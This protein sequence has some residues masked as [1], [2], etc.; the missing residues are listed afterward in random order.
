MCGSARRYS[1]PSAAATRPPQTH[2]PHSAPTPHPQQHPPSDAPAPS[3]SPSRASAVH[4]RKQTDVHS[5]P[6]PARPPRCPLQ[7]AAPH[8]ARPVPAPCAESPARPVRRDRV[9]PA[10]P[11]RQRL[12]PHPH[13]R[14]PP[15]SP[16][17]QPACQFRSVHCGPP[18]SWLPSHTDF[19]VPQSSAPEQS[20]P[21]PRQAPPRPAHRPRDRTPAHPADEPRPESPEQ[22]SA[23]PPRCAPRLPPAPESPSS[24]WWKATD[25]DRQAHSNPLHPARELPA[26]RAV[27]WTLALPMHA[28]S[29]ARQS[30]GCAPPQFAAPPAWQ[31]P[32]APTPAASHAAPW[33]MQ[34]P[35]AVDPTFRHSAAARDPRPCARHPQ[36]RSPRAAALSPTLRHDQSVVAVLPAPG[37][38]QRRPDSADSTVASSLSPTSLAQLPWCLAA[39]PA[40]RTSLEYQPRA[41]L[42]SVDTRQCPSLQPP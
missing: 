10:P 28:A 22:D 31:A 20:T 19:P 9:R 27:R 5:L 37:R 7:P 40:C 25:A 30:V 16:W 38:A 15:Q 24:A 6:A 42:Y 34:R 17:A 29:A 21:C 14:W 11:D 1:L 13:S 39:D 2:C 8:R 35:A 41:P 4:R 18:A 33:K 3:H 23:R 12:H 26:P 36:S 32:D